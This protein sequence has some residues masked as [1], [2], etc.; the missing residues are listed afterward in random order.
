MFQNPSITQSLMCLMRLVQYIVF[1]FHQI[2]FSNKTSSSSFGSGAMLMFYVYRIV[3]IRGQKL[4]P[5]SENH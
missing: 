5:G 2:K 4:D 1:V 3:I